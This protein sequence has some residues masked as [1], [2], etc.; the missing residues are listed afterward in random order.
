[1]KKFFFQNNCNDWERQNDAMK[2]FRIWFFS[3]LNYFFPHSMENDSLSLFLSFLLIEIE[4]DD[5]FFNFIFFSHFHFHFLPPSINTIK[6]HTHTHTIYVCLSWWWYFWWTFFR[7]QTSN[8]DPLCW[9]LFYS[10]YWREWNQN[11]FS[12]FFYYS[13]IPLFWTKK[14]T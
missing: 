12:F 7:T 2:E 5:Q 6:A 1:M 9:F 13:T 4:I 10:I 14:N 3:N 8:C 11:E